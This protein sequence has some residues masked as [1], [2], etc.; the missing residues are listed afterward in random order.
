MHKMAFMIVPLLFAGLWL[1]TMARFL[2]RV[3]RSEPAAY[4]SLGRPVMRFLMWNVPADP[5]ADAP[6]RLVV[7]PGGIDAQT[8][9]TP[10][11]VHATL[12]LIGWIVRGG[13]G[14]L[15]DPA[16]RRLGVLLR[17]LA[18]VFPLVVLGT[19]AMILR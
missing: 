15:S 18:L 16:C 3:A 8:C 6:H 7:G 10:E 11:Q 2:S 4:E 14:E 5:S 1:V 9:Y 12:R 13:Y 19:M 17:V